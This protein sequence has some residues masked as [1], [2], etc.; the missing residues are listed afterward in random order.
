M[1]TN[2]RHLPFLHLASPAVVGAWAIAFEIPHL[3]GM[4]AHEPAASD[5]RLF[6]VAAEAGLTWGWPHVYDPA[7]Q[8][9]LSLAFSPRVPPISPPY[10]FLTPP[11]PARLLALPSLVR[12]P[13]SPF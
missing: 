8:Q 5:F 9:E 6:Y 3:I 2:S 11:L 13:P 10:F 4:I 1:H 12:L 7:K